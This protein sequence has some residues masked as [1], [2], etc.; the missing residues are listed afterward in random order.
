MTIIQSILFGLL[1]GLTEFLPISS[2]GHLTALYHFFGVEEHRL[3]FTICLH[4]GTLVAVFIF[5][6]GDILSLFSTQKKL[7]IL[8]IIGSVPTAIMAFFL[9]ALVERLFAEVKVVGVMLMI[10]GV[11]LAIGSTMSSRRNLASSAKSTSLKVWQALLIGISQGAALIP[12]ISRSGATIS[13]AL[14]CGTERGLSI[15]YSFLL[16]I[17]A[18]LGAFLYQ[19]KEINQAAIYPEFTFF[20]FLIGAIAA[21]LTGLVS[22][23][24]L[25]KIIIKGKL[26]YFTPY[27]LAAGLFLF[28]AG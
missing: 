17:P 5:F 15:R 25:S 28:L 19:L 21:M 1:Q 7:G 16:S 22:L 24:V 27:C 11:W 26:H 14:L 9:S 4:I 13:T 10:T 20:T 23:R 18:I 6:W 12:G 2:S 3:L 8:I